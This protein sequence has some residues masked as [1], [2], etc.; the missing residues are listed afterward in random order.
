MHIE[1]VRRVCELDGVDAVWLDMTVH[2]AKKLY[3]RE[4][5]S[6]RVRMAEVAVAHL[7]RAGVT[8]LMAEMGEKGWGAEYFEALRALAEGAAAGGGGGGGGGGGRDVAITWVMGWTSSS[9]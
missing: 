4:V 9:A 8:Q 7:P 5:A 3:I 6:D 2:V 1:L